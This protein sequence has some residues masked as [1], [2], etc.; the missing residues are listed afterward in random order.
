MKFS[1]A[2]AALLANASATSVADDQKM[3]QITK[4]VLYGALDAEDFKDVE[5]CM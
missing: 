5:N 1:L 4:G 3:Y 2:T